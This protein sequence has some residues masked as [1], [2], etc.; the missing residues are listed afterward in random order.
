MRPLFSIFSLF[1]VLCHCVADDIILR[2]GK[3][4]TITHP[5]R[6][7]DSLMTDI[8]G[9]GGQLGY[10]VKD[11]VKMEFP[12]PDQLKMASDLLGLGQPQ[13]AIS[14]LDPVLSFYSSFSDIPGNWWLPAALLKA[15]ALQSL[16]KENEAEPIL[17]EIARLATDPDDSRLAKVRLAAL[18]A[19][20]V[21]VG[22]ENL[23]D[24]P[25]AIAAHRAGYKDALPVYDE[26]VDHSFRADVLA[27]AWIAK[28]DAS[29]AL[30]QVDAAVIAYFHIPVFFPEQ[31]Q[32]MPRALYG[33]AKAFVAMA[34]YKRAKDTIQQLQTD[35]GA[36]PESLLARRDLE[37]IHA[38]EME[39]H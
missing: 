6:V 28:G 10:S 35:F 9:T 23:H 24:D 5:S 37:T 2:S 38:R 13:Q 14:I 3:V 29:L 39:K 4:I 7:G 12:R 25:V 32:L 20:R 1:L 11:I 30:D 33:S 36:S 18:S 16:H 21:A 31:T 19:R 15:S 17:K 22:A 8:P 26:V 34:D 27:E